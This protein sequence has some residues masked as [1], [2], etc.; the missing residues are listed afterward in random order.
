MQRAT[1]VTRSHGCAIGCTD[2]HTCACAC[3][4]ATT[5]PTS[6]T[7]S[8]TKRRCHVGQR[9][10][11]QRRSCSRLLTPQTGWHATPTPARLFALAALSFVQYILVATVA[12]V[13]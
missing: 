4:C 8:R 7:G 9:S 13:A 6:A 5:S 1:R 2:T 10:A 12:A 11:R 3:A